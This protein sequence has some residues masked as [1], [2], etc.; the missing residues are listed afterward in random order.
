LPKKKPLLDHPLSRFIFSH[1]NFHIGKNE[2]KVA[3]FM[4][5][6]EPPLNKLEL[7][8][9]EVRRLTEIKIWRIGTRVGKQSQR[10]LCARADFYFGDVLAAGLTAHFDPW[11][12]RHVNLVGWP[13]NGKKS[14]VMLIA[15][16]LAKAATLKV[17]P[18]GPIPAR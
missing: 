6:A 13:E 14:E 2:V 7:S 12:G 15:A 16:K 4:P 18:E 5:R 9:F 10:P 17:P 11:P 3:A 1:S 8:V